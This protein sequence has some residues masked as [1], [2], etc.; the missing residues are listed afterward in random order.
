MSRHQRI[1]WMKMNQST[2]KNIAWPSL[3]KCSGLHRTADYTFNMSHATEDANRLVFI[4]CL[5]VEIGFHFL[6][7][8]LMPRYSRI[9]SIFLALVSIFCDPTKRIWKELE[10]FTQQRQQSIARKCRKI[11][12][13]ITAQISLLLQ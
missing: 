7:W 10:I 11:G 5:P 12:A 1:M 3:D 6:T 9:S 2:H 8:P 4:P 13:D